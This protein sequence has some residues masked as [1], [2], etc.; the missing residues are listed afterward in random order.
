[1]NRFIAIAAATLVGTMSLNSFAAAQYPPRLSLPV[2]CAGVATVQVQI[3]QQQLARPVAMVPTLTP[4][5]QPV[6]SAPVI[7]PAVM[8]VRA[9]VAPEKVY[10][11]R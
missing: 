7:K 3:Q 5:F 4:A 10:Y 1:M 9:Y 8:P 2:A 6:A 11:G